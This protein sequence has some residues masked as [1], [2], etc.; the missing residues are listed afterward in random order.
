MSKLIDVRQ[1]MIC[2]G[3]SSTT[4]ARNVAGTAQKLAAELI[5]QATSTKE[6][7]TLPNF[8]FV[9][10][11]ALKAVRDAEYANFLQAY[12]G[13]IGTAGILP[14]QIEWE[15]PDRPEKVEPAN[16]E[17]GLSLGQLTIVINM[18]AEHELAKH[19]QRVRNC[20]MERALPQT[21]RA[22]YGAG[23]GRSRRAKNWLRA[24]K[25][26]WQQLVNKLSATRP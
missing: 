10:A 8:V 23:R 24:P 5:A 26:L 12:A 13:V 19:R 6:A 4:F 16:L 9:A 17:N 21:S 14:Q 11:R 3:G 7:N 1:A 15:P 18:A 20:F 25:R 22:V 2:C